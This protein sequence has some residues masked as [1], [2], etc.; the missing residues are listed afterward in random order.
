MTPRTY[1]AGYMGD[2]FDIDAHVQAARHHLRNVDYDTMVGT[3]LSGA[4]VVPGLARALGKYALIVRKPRDG[5]HACSTAEGKLGDR[6]VFVDDF[7]STGATQGRVLDKIADL[8]PEVEFVGT[9]CYAR[10]MMGDGPK[11]EPPT[12]L[13]RRHVPESDPLPERARRGD[14]LT[15]DALKDRFARTIER[16]RT[17]LLVDPVLRFD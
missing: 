15:T 16:T 6:W 14:L 8:A 10:G 2:P 4:L 11:F 17:D 5:S 9:F 1:T 7:I 12:T 13:M 3:G